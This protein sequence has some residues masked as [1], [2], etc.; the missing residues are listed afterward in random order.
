VSKSDKK[1]IVVSV[2]VI[3]T[4]NFFSKSLLNLLFEFCYQEKGCGKEA[5]GEEKEEEESS[6]LVKMCQNV[7]KF[8]QNLSKLLKNLSK[9]EQKFEPSQ[10]I[11]Q[12]CVKFLN[13]LI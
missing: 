1:I 4:F 11:A 3:K 7:S 2:G 8:V 5:E 12:I 6:Y 10:T 9:I 13:N